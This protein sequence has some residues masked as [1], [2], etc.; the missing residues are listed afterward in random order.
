MPEATAAKPLSEAVEAPLQ[1]EEIVT[2][3]LTLLSHAQL[4][5]FSQEAAVKAADAR[6]YG[7]TG[8]ALILS[9]LALACEAALTLK[10]VRGEHA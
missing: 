5:A 7:D 4:A 1:T 9:S 2:E 6:R 3:S 8:Q 10:I